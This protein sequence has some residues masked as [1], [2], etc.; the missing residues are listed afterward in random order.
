MKM[1]LQVKPLSIRAVSFRT[2]TTTTDYEPDQSQVTTQ[3]PDGGGA[4]SGEVNS[5][6]GT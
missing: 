6:T 2:T 4:G 1:L 5:V 3:V